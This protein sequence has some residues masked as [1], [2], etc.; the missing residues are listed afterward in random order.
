MAIIDPVSAE[1]L[2][3][4]S[5][6]KNNECDSEIITTMVSELASV[7]CCGIVVVLWLCWPHF[8]GDAKRSPREGLACCVDLRKN[9]LLHT[10]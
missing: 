4:L 2:G 7:N 8:L 10:R 3:K 6:Y 1:V 9:R 5:T